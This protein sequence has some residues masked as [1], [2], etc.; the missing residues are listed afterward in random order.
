VINLT[1][2]CQVGVRKADSVNAPLKNSTVGFHALEQA[3]V[4]SVAFPLPVPHVT[5]GRAQ[6]FKG[7][8]FGFWAILPEQLLVEHVS[9]HT[10]KGWN[11]EVQ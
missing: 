11:I 1:R 8:L 9:G 6:Q 7:G 5:Q 2:V 10:A 3:P 4:K